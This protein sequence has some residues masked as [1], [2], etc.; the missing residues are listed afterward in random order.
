[1]ATVPNVKR[2][3]SSV[4]EG[5]SNTTIEFNLTADLATAL[6]DTKD[7]VTRI[8]TLCGTS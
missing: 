7:A 1:M 8:P 4:T 2:V 6:D 5:V 3:I